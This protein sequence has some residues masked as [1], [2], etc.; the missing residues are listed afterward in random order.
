MR[1]QELMGG[2]DLGVVHFL[3]GDSTVEKALDFMAEKKI[4]ALIVTEAEQPVGI[5]TERDV[6]RC[7]FGH[8]GKPLSEIRLSDVMTNKLITA[9]PEAEILSTVFM[10]LQTDIRH[11]PVVRDEKIIEMLSI[12]DLIRHQ[13]N[14]LTTDLE[15]LQNYLADLQEAGND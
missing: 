11:L 8:R 13:L 7:H 6:P 10:M 3:S 1:I 2:K 15:H 4:S 5:F 12:R 9:E 14:S